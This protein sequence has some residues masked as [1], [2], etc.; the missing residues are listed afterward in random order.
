MTLSSLGWD[1][2][3]AGAFQPFAS[4]NFLPA[5]VALEHKHACVLLS[6]RGEITATCTGRLL[7]ETA[8][9][10]ALPAV[11]DWVAVRLRPESLA[12]GAGVALV[13]DIHAVL[14]RRTAFTRRAV[15]DADA[16]Q[17]LATN[18]DT[19]FLV[20]GLDRDFNLR[21]IERYL[22]VARAS[23]AQPVVVLN[24]SDLHPD[25]RGAEAEVRRITRTAP[26][27]TLSAARGD[28]IAALAPWLVPGATVALLGSSGAGKS[29][30]I[31]RLL[32]KQ[33]QDTG[34][35]SHAM[36][37]GRHTTT[38][39]ELLAL[40]GGALVIDTPGLRELQLWGVDESAVAETFPEVAALA[41]ECRFPDC[42]HQREPG[43]AVRAALDDGTLDPTRWASYEKL[44]REQAY[45]ARRVDPVLARAERDRWKKIYQGQRARERIEGRWE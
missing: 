41:A 42:T 2:F 3:F 8:T 44:Q 6:A 39:R 36:N 20:T 22:A 5:R 12:S 11:G 4:E 21:R 16:E 7:H 19:V 1:D 35:L 38:H 23:E 24:K 26:V 40:P 28:G 30:L 17:V 43:C 14:P 18:V 33:R 15:G 29:T 34:P 37:K 13:G 31:N 25:A 10:A 27:V 9:R 45:A 32:G